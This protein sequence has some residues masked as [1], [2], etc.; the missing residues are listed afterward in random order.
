MEKEILT[1]EEAAA[2]LQIGKKS[3]YKLAKEERI[4]CKKILN[5]WRFEKDGL[6][7]WVRGGKM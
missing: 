2:Y 5:K 7:T 3:L 4:P 6:K 1:I